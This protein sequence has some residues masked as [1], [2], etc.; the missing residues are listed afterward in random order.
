MTSS[1]PEPQVQMDFFGVSE[2][3]T[4]PSAFARR[5]THAQQPTPPES[6]DPDPPIA[7]PPQLSW[8]PEVF[9]W[10]DRDCLAMLDGLL[11]DQLRL[12]ADGRTAPEVHAEI[13]AWVAEP[14]RSL[15]A[16]KNAP[17]SFQACCAGAGV[18]FEEMQEL[19]LR[20]FAPHLV[21][22]LG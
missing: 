1:G 4:E 13:I 19:T 7:Q 12:L 18:D 17:F 9:T 5:R 14:K 2:T 16:L 21:A 15:G 11:V 3:L 10:K 20:M 8:L 6:L 22:H